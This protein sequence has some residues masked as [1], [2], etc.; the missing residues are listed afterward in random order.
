[1]PSLHGVKGRKSRTQL[2]LLPPSLP[3]SQIQS[4]SVLMWTAASA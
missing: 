1:M 2:Q 3:G 4:L